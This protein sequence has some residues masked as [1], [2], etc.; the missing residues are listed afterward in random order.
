LKYLSKSKRHE[1][2]HSKKEYQTNPLGHC[3]IV[4][5]IRLSN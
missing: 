2:I 5:T 1:L 4:L 3:L